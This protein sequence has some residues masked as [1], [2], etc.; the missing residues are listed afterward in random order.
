MNAAAIRTLQTI[1]AR[2]GAYAGEIDGLRG[3][4][5]DAAVQATLAGDTTAPVGWRDWPAGRQAVALLQIMS[6]DAGIDPGPVDGLWGPRTEAAAARLAR[7]EPPLPP[8]PGGGAARPAAAVDWPSQDPV[9]MTAFYGPNGV[10]GGRTPPLARVPCP[11]PLRLAWDQSV[12]IGAISIHESCADSL[13]RVLARVHAAYGTEGALRLGLDL[14][15]GSY[16]PRRMRGGSRWSV[17]AW[18]AAIDWDPAR[19]RLS[20]GR[21]RARLA[22]PEFAEWW[23]IWEDEGW[24]SLGRARNFDWMHVQAARL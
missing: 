15:G 16:N 12:T 14:F 20:W 4:R 17:H 22:G 13:A 9:A 6:R 8:R 23:C 2:A 24:T 21:D 19:N 7:D 10:P 11:W 5:T 18:G 3:P 1:L